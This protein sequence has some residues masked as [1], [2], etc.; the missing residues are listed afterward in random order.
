MDNFWKKLKPPIVGLAPMD[1]VTDAAFRHMVC[2]YSKPSVV[3]TEFTNVEGLARGASVMLRAFYYG[4]GERPIVGQ[5]YGV[6]VES[7]YKAAVM[8]CHMGFDGVD[9]NMGCPANKVARKGS[10][11]GLIKTP[12]L[13]T[14]IVKAT[15]KGV[16]DWA[17]GVTLEEADVHENIIAECKLL[18][19]AGLIAR[20]S[21]RR[22]VP[23]SV[24]TRIGI[25]KVVAESWVKHLAEV[26]P[27]AITMHGR[28]LK[29]AYAGN[30]DWEVLAKA[31]RVAR[32]AGIF[33]LGNGD[34]QNMEDARG[35]ID[36][37]G[38]DGVLAGRAAMG[39]PWFFGEKEA[40]VKQR[41]KAAA[42]HAKLF[43]KF[44]PDAPFVA[45]RK[46]LAWYCKGFEGAK[47]LRMKFMKVEKSDDVKKI[48]SSFNVNH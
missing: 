26:K 21:K 11:A 44:Y 31:A 43:E 36:E 9:I 13:A 46:H 18:R 48:I 33:F 34:V 6:E 27:A 15:K 3:F 47:E 12:A 5:V 23:V 25:D 42:E 45:M 8:L 40:T 19:R 17:N 41:L 24:K 4:K 38:V 10:G 29:Q 20:S 39:N 30:A 1:G 32:D 2:K 28:T 16:K 14:K 7:Y 22:V 35:K 37:Y